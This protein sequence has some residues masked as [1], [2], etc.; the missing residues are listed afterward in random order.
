[1]YWISKGYAVAAALAVAFCAR[2]SWGADVMIVVQRSPLAAFRHY[3]AVAV[4]RDVKAGDRL[5]LVREPDNPYD[6][7]AVRIEWRGRKLGYLPRRNND[8]VARQ[9]D[10][11]TA[12]EARVAQVKENRNRS[13]RL[14]VEVVASLQ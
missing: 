4:W 12:L 14:E 9:L 10:R 2:P 1:M 3:D 7:N 6:P 13:V 5:E 11:G 8:A